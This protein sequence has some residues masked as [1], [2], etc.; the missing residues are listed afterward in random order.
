MQQM[1]RPNAKAVKVFGP[2]STV[3][4]LKELASSFR[5]DGH[6]SSHGKTVIC[7]TICRPEMRVTVAVA[8]SMGVTYETVSVDVAILLV[9]RHH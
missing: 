4:A 6:Q 9:E 8:V 2:N 7:C 3:T 5:T 1:Y